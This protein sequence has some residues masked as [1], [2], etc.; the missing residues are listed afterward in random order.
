M[1][2]SEYN[3]LSK[4]ER[5]KVSFKQIPISMKIVVFVF[6]A[7]IVMMSIGECSSD[8]KSTQ[9]EVAA[10]VRLTQSQ[11]DSAPYEAKM[12]WIESYLKT[13]GSQ[14]EFSAQMLRAVRNMF[15]FPEEVKFGFGEAP[16]FKN[17]T[18]VDADMGFVFYKGYVTAKNAFGMKSKYVFQ[19]R[20]VVKPDSLYI[21]NVSVNEVR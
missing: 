14:Y 19:I 1:K 6:L 10:S 16:L 12:K 15:N 13:G 18:L 17:G 8:T 21:D 20:T 7:T 11:F 5:K 4:E 9:P 3:A 2:F